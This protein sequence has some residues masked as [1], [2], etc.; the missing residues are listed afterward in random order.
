ML[1]I[2]ILVGIHS[3][4]V[5]EMY[6]KQIKSAQA[7]LEITKTMRKGVMPKHFQ[8]QCGVANIRLQVIEA[9]FFL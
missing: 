6:Q 1:F 7:V 4:E 3:Q 8:K 2:Y 5:S 9:H